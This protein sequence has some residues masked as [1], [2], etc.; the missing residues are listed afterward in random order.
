ME[1][2]LSQVLAAIERAG[3]A[4]VEVR[5]AAPSVGAV[6]GAFLPL[7]WID[8]GVAWMDRHLVEADRLILLTSRFPDPTGAEDE[9]PPPLDVLEGVVDPATCALL[10]SAPVRLAAYEA[11]LLLAPPA[12]LV[13][14]VLHRS[15]G[16]A[17]AF[18]GEPLRVHRAASSHRLR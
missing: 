13:E 7:G 16:L 8:G 17:G 15:G 3:A 1:V 9:A 14:L 12:F 4:Q 10:R 11:L 2:A 5:T 6:Q 18:A